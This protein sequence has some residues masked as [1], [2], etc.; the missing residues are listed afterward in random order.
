M[1]PLTPNASWMTTTAPR[2]VPFGSASNTF[3]V[4]P[5]L[6][7]DTVWLIRL[8]F[9]LGSDSEVTLD[10]HNTTRPTDS[11]SAGAVDLQLDDL[12]LALP[13]R[14]KDVVGVLGEERPA[15]H[16]RRG[17]VELHRVGHELAVD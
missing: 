6:S 3:I 17:L 4:L 2:A 5:A 13:E 14:P 8:L 15:C 9:R 7:T 1:C 12:L 16:R 10:C 11:S